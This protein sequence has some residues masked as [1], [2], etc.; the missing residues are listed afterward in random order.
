MIMGE[1]GQ[2]TVPKTLREK[3]GL[4]PATEVEFVE[5]QGLLVLRRK[6]DTSKRASGLR[7]WVGFLSEQ[8]EDVDGFIE[9]IRG[10]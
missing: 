7:R 10:R 4:T 2:V 8:P 9:D 1:R 6:T 5:Q 3:Y